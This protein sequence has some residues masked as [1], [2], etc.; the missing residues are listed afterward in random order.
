MAEIFDE[1]Y[2]EVVARI[3]SYEMPLRLKLICA[4]ENLDTMDDEWG[5]MTYGTM[6]QAM[7][8]IIEAHNKTAREEA[9]A[10]FAEIGALIPMQDDSGKLGSFKNDPPDAIVGAVKR[11]INTFDE[12]LR[13]SLETNHALCR[14][15]EEAKALVFELLGVAVW[16][17]DRAMGEAAI[18][19]QGTITKA[20]KWLEGK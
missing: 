5:T 2:K 1:R 7:L 18:D 16:A 9:K 20:T 3:I 19:I 14:K 17:K 12:A 10:L 8:E 13:S 11:R 6:V 15:L 4:L